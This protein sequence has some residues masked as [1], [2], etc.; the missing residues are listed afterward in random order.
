MA[1]LQDKL[2]STADNL[3]LCIDYLYAAYDSIADEA[4]KN[5]TFIEV[6]IAAAL[7]GGLIDDRDVLDKD[8]FVKD[9]EKLM[10][11]A[12]NHT[13]RVTKKRIEKIQDLPL[14]KYVCV[15]FEYNKHNHWVLFK[16]QTLLYNSFEDSQCFKYGKPVDARII[17]KVL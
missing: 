1:A 3:C 7:V 17:E 6:A 5:K 2:K 14:D 12:T 15:N 9:A 16:G 8:G 4:E 13:F 11:L 10:F